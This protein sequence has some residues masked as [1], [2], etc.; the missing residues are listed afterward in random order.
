MTKKL[1]R[2]ADP[3]FRASSFGFLSSFV[4]RA[5][6]L[7]EPSSFPKFRMRTMAQRAK[8]QLSF[9]GVA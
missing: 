5:S 8:H 2:N 7:L 6:S 1:H 3:I 9:R 4:I